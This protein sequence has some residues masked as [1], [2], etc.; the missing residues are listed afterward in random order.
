MSKVEL[1]ERENEMAKMRLNFTAQA[2]QLEQSLELLNN[3]V[4]LYQ[5]SVKDK[6]ELLKVAKVAY[7]SDRM[8]TEDYLKYEDDLLM[9][10]SKLYHAD[11]QRWETL[12]KLAVIYGNSI[13]DMV[14]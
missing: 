9:E 8:S 14:K 7:E 11:A 10:R 3:S 6:E 12:M 1:E 2:E 5:K 4:K 13:E